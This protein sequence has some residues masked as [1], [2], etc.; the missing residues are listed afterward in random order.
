MKFKKSIIA[1]SR[2][3]AIAPTQMWRML[4][5]VHSYCRREKMLNALSPFLQ[6]PRKA[7]CLRNGTK[8]DFK[9]TMEPNSRPDG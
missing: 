6:E 4:R 5:C 9:A 3:S 7:G 1:V 8:A 2:D